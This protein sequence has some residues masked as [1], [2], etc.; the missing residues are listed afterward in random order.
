MS[1]WKVTRQNEPASTTASTLGKTETEPC[2]RLR[3][4]SF[5]G[6]LNQPNTTHDVA[7]EFVA[8]TLDHIAVNCGSSRNSTAVDT[9]HWTRCLFQI[10]DVSHGSK[11][12]WFSSKVTDQRLRSN[13]IPYTMVRLSGWPFTYTFRVTPGQKLIRLH[14]YPALYRG[15]FQ[16]SEAFFSVKAGPYTLLSNFSASL[17]VDAFGIQYLVK[18]YCVNVEEDRP[19]IIMFSRSRL[20]NSDEVYAFVNGI[21]IMP[22][23]AAL[24]HT[25]EGNPA[26]QIIGKSY[27]FTIDNDIALEKVHP[28]N[29]GRS[30]S[31][32]IEDTGMFWDWYE[33]SSY[34]LEKSCVKPVTTTIR[35]KYTSIPPYTAPQK[36]YQTSW[37]MVPDK[38]ANKTE[39]NFT[40][41]LT[42]DLGF[43]Y[44]LR[45]H[46][47]ALEYEI[48]ESGRMEFSIFVNEQVVE[49]KGDLIKWSDGNGVAV[50]KDLW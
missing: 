47:C 6:N 22:M 21:E 33:D 40:W 31:S 49:A 2:A 11:S 3:E 24:Y 50:Y 46:F 20:G 7:F 41:R 17:T 32:S 26:V 13:P 45:L 36:V 42:V 19:L 48:K 9:R 15:G 25:R 43:Q 30:S 34:L 23:P 44:L 4:F 28:L 8:N 16:R 14:F 10:H 18:E 37:S 12:K 1:E 27:R 5:I 39:F 38:L 35:N 29:I